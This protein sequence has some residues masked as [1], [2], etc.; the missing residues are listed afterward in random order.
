MRITT[1][2]VEVENT[3]PF[4]QDQLHA[5]CDPKYVTR[6]WSIV[7]QVDRL[8]Q[9]YRTPFIGKSSPVLF[10]WG[11]FDLSLPTPIPSLPAVESRRSSRTR[12]TTTSS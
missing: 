2:S 6:F 11:S 1:S 8:L 4:D 3:I 12:P 9:A 7:L 5:S 10:W